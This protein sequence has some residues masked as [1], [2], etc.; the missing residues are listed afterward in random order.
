MIERFGHDKIRLVECPVCRAN[1]NGKK[2]AHHI[3]NHR[4]SDFGLTPAGEIR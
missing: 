3:A 2:T 1:L 4:P